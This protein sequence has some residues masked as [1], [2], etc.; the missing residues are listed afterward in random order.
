MQKKYVYIV[1]S[2][3]VTVLIAS[4]IGWAI[5]INKQQQ[6]LQSETQDLGYFGDSTSS[7]SRGDSFFGSF[8][9][10]S[11]D[12]GSDSSASTS[13]QRPILRQL[14]NLP[15]AGFVKN[16]TGTVRFVDRRT[17]YVFE[18]D[19]SDGTTT[20]IDQ[21]TVP[22]VYNA[23]F[24]DNGKKVV[25]QYTDKDLQVISVLSGS[26]GEGE[27]AS[28][29]PNILEIT[30][31]STNQKLALLERSSSGSELYI[32][33]LETNSKDLIFHSALRGWNI[34]W[35]KSVIL[36]SQKPSAG[37]PGSAYSV[38]VSTGLTSLLLQQKNGLQTNMSPDADKILFSS[39]KNGLPALSIFNSTTSAVLDLPL[40]G[41]PE[42]CVWHPEKPLIYC[43]IPNK[44]PEG[45]YPDIWHQGTIHFVDS[46]YE[47]NAETGSSTMIIS[48]ETTDGLSLDIVKLT[49]DVSTGE[50]FFV[51][52][53]DQTF[54]SLTLPK[55]TS[56]NQNESSE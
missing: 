31:D 50:L 16:G 17:G 3:I 51:N 9:S 32:Y 29:S 53:L 30:T 22:Q 43:A 36:V 1:T 20:R 6:A 55:S 28:L 14:Y 46:I 56:F 12:T 41:L 2:I 42:K 40:S 5:F 37:L 7:N 4:L 19:L 39:T 11:T 47:I 44:F 45:D 26:T 21:T 27:S 25:R 8:F 33:N 34:Q 52:K 35:E 38:A 18:K 13:E 49:F 48:P 15:T 10:N 24:L 54:W 23:L